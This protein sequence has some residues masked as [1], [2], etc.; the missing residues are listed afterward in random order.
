MVILWMVMALAAVVQAAPVGK[1]TNL[2]G[3]A[4]VTVS[5]QPAKA[6]SI[7]QA[8]NVGDIIRTKS[9]SKCEVTW[10]DGSIARMAADSRLQVTAF[11]L[12]KTSRK[13]ILSLFRGKVQN[14]VTS[15]AKLFGGKGDSQYEVHTPTSVCGVRGTTFF[16][17]YENGIS[18][19]L[20]A[21]GSGYMYSRGRPGERKTVTPGIWM[22]VANAH[23][24]PSARHATPGEM[25]K[26]FRDTNLSD[27]KKDSGKSEDGKGITVAGGGG[28]TGGTMLGGDPTDPTQSSPEVGGS[29][30][31]VVTTNVTG[32][33][34]EKTP[35]VPVTPP[36][37]MTTFSLPVVVEGVFDGTLK[38]TISNTTNT[39]TINLT[40]AGT[41]SNYV[42]STAGALSDGSTA[43][44]YLTGISG[45]WRGLFTGLSRKDTSVSILKGD[46]SGAYA[47][48]VGNIVRSTGYT[49]AP[50]SSYQSF[51]DLPLL[52][53]Q[54]LTIS[55]EAF[56][57]P[58][59]S[60]P[61][62]ESGIKTDGVTGYNTQSG[63]IL[64]IWGVNTLGGTY[65]NTTGETSK[66]IP[67]YHF[68]YGSPSLADHFAFGTVTVTD[69][70]LGHTTVSGVDSLSYLDR[71]YIGTLSLDYRGV[72]NDRQEYDSVGTG[73]Y[74]L[75]PLSWSGD[76]GGSTGF[77]YGPAS[78]YENYY[79]SEDARSMMELVAHDMGLVGGETPFW[80]QTSHLVAMGYIADNDLNPVSGETV[81]GP[82]LWNSSIAAQALTGSNVSEIFTP[83][84]EFTGVTAGI[85]KDG[86]MNGSAYAIYKTAAGQ[87][88]WLIGK[89]TISGSYDSDLG[90]WQAGGDL[91]PTQRIAQLPAGVAAEDLEVFH[92][93]AIGMTGGNFTDGQGNINN[94]E[95]I[96][97]TTF[98][99][100]GLYNEEGDLEKI[101]PLRW[102]IY[103]IQMVYS[104]SFTGKPSGDTTWTAKTGGYGPT[105][106]NAPFFYLADISGAWSADG[107]ITG[108]LSGRY[109]TP[110]YLGVLSGPFYGIYNVDNVDPSVGGWI[111]QSI[112]TYNVTQ[113]LAHSAT[114]GMAFYGYG[115]SETEGGLYSNMD[116]SMYHA[117]RA[118]GLLGGTTAPWSGSSD[119]MA[120]GLF[121][122]DTMPGTSLWNTAVE[123]KVPQELPVA[124]ETYGGIY[125]GY[126]AAL[127]R[128]TGY[129]GAIR[130]IYLTPPD[131]EGKSAAGFL[132]ADNTAGTIYRFGQQD[133]EEGYTYG[134]WESTG[135]NTLTAS[136]PLATGIDAALVAPGYGS[137]D[138]HVSGSFNG[139]GTLANDTYSGDL[140]FFVNGSTP[141]P[142]GVYDLK[143]GYDTGSG[144]FSGK[145]AGETAWSANLGG[146]MSIGDNAA[147]S[148]A[149]YNGG[150]EGYWIADVGGQWNTSNEI[151]G[152][153]VNGTFLTPTHMG[154][155]SGPL[156]GLY[157]VQG[158]DESGLYG[159]WVGQSVG[160][161]QGVP[162]S[163]VSDMYAEISHA[164][165]TYNGQFSYHS[166]ETQT[167]YYN[168]FYLSD[169][170]RGYSYNQPTANTYPNTNTEYYAD[171]T[172]YVQVYDANGNCTSSYGTWDTTKGLAFL[173]EPTPPEGETAISDGAYQYVG[174]SLSGAMSGLLGGTDS[175]WTGSDIPFTALGQFGNQGDSIWY[176][177]LSSYNHLN[178]TYTTYDGGA[179]V[180]IMGGTEINNNLDGKFLSLYVAPDGSAGYLGGPLSGALYPGI[181]MFKMDG[182][183]NRTQP[184]VSHNPGVLPEN[185]HDS[186]WEGSM[187]ANLA[188][189]FTGGGE[190]SNYSRYGAYGAGQALV[191]EIGYSSGIAMSIVN[192]ETNV[193]QNWGIYGML[194]YGDFTNPSASSWTAKVG[195]S[196]SFGAYNLYSDENGNRNATSDRGYWLADISDGALSA[197]GKL[198][199]TLANGKFITKTKLGILGGDLSGSLNST[200]NLW[201]AFSLGTWE[202]TPLAF[203]SRMSAG[204]SH[205]GREY[206]GQ[207]SY[208]SGETK[209]GYY[210]Y[211]YLSDNS[212]GYS[213]NQPTANTYPYTQTYYYQD[214]TTYSYGY[215]KNNTYFESHGTWDTTKSLAFL[216]EP[217]PPE[218][219]T[220]STDYACD[221]FTAISSGHMSGLLGGTDSLWTGSNIP[222]TV[223]G[224]FRN[225]RSSI[226]HAN[227]SSD[228]YLNDTY[229]TYDN[230][231]YV[232]IMGGTEINNNLEGKFLSLY[233][234]PDGSAGYLKG[235]LSGALH[236]EVGIFEMTGTLNRVQPS[237]SHNPGVLPENLRDSIWEGSMGATLAGQFTDGGKINGY[238]GYGAGE[239][240]ISE[241]GYGGYGGGTTL[242][243]VNWET[244]VAQNWGIYGMA[245]YGEFTNPSASVWKA[246]VGGNSSFGA[247][248]L[249]TDENGNRNA[250]D[251]WGYW[252]A[253]ISDGALDATG[254]LTGTLVNGKFITKTKLGIL[255]GDLSGSLNSTHNL[256]DAVSLGTWEG[257]PL[258]YSANL[259]G[260][261]GYYNTTKGEEG[262]VNDGGCITGLTGGLSSLFGGAADVVGLGVYSRN[263]NS[264]LF[265]MTLVNADGGPETNPFQIYSGGAWFPAGVDHPEWF[266]SKMM[267]FYARN[268]DGAKYTEIGLL[269]SGP[270]IDKNGDDTGYSVWGNLYSGTGMWEIPAGEDQGTLSQITKT[271]TATSLTINESDWSPVATVSGNLQGTLRMKSATLDGI[272]KWGIWMS[273]M[274]GTYT[275]TIP[276][277]WAGR[278]GWTETNAYGKPSYSLATLAGHYYAYDGALWGGI[279]GRFLNP[280]NTG[281]FT[282][283]MIGVSGSGNWQ[284]LGLGS[285]EVKET[286]AFSSILTGNQYQN[287]PGIVNNKEYQK[288]Y[289]NGSSEN[290]WFEP[291]RYE[292][293]YFVPDAGTYDVTRT[294][295]FE[296]A[297]RD[298]GGYVYK[299][300][301][302]YFPNGKWVL[303]QKGS[304]VTHPA[305]SGVTDPCLDLSDPTTSP[306]FGGT[307]VADP[308]VPFTSDN[309]YVR[310]FSSAWATNALVQNGA[311]TGIMG[312]LNNVS[313]W[314]STK[315]NKTNLIM[316]GSHDAYD[317][318]QI[319]GTTGYYYNENKPNGAFVSSL[320]GTIQD[321]SGNQN[322]LEGLII[323][324]YIDPDGYA[325]VLKGNVRGASYRGVNMWESTDEEGAATLYRYSTLASGLTPSDLLNENA[326]FR[327]NIGAGINSAVHGTFGGS[328]AIDSPMGIMGTTASIASQPDWGIFTMQIGLANTF[329]DKPEAATGWASTLF[330]SGMFG[331]YGEAY[332]DLGYWYADLTSGTWSGGKLT[333]TL[334]G[335]FLTHKKLG[336]L[337]GA[338]LGTYDG[339]TS[340][341]WQATS[342][343]TYLKTKDVLFSSEIWG[344]TDALAE[345]K[346]G[347]KNDYA[348]GSSY[349][350]WYGSSKAYGNSTYYNATAHTRTMTRFDIQGTGAGKPHKDVWVQFYGA[351]KIWDTADDTYTFVTK[352][353]YG[354]LTDYQNDMLNLEKDPANPGQVVAS[355]T[356]MNFRD[357]NFNGILAGTENLWTNLGTSAATP[358]S[359]MGDIDVFGNA[360]R[361]LFTGT[362]VSFDPLVNL[363]PFANSTSPI[364]GAYYANL[365][366]AFGTKTVADDTLDGMISGLYLTP[367]GKAGVLYGAFT[368]NNNPDIGFWKGSGELKGYQLLASTNTMTPETFAG[369]LVRNSSEFRWD[370]P[371]ASSDPYLGGSLYTQA[372]SKSETAFINPSYYAGW[373]G[374][375]FGIYSG[376]AGGTYDLTAMSSESYM[377]VVID[378]TS[379][380]YSSTHWDSTINPVA[381]NVRSGS[382]LHN[383]VFDP[384]TATGRLAVTA[385]Y[386]Q[387]V[388]IIQGGDIKGLFDPV[389]RTWQ[390]ATNGT[391]METTAFVNLVNTFATDAEKNA[392]M[393]AMKIPAISVGSVDLAGSRG[394]AGDFLSVN[395][396]GVNF[397]AYSTGQ[398][399][400]IF[401][402]NNVTGTYDVS[403]LNGALPAAVNLTA[404][405]MS[406]FSAAS[407][408][409]TPKVWNTAANKWGAEVTG[410]GTMTS[411]ATGIV[412]KGG[413]AGGL[414]GGVSG[415]FGG[416]AAGVVRTGV[417]TP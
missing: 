371:Y 130:T 131:A 291:L 92:D 308:T 296:S 61:Y 356:Q 202:G 310:S 290:G 110:L 80:S 23:S 185:L 96:M 316:M 36:T 1:V 42:L 372:Y 271:G 366:G 413:A 113:K 29:G 331:K 65:V 352:D 266:E 338:L 93:F 201:E 230:G 188:G 251:D 378:Q 158:S 304:G 252:M 136:A 35:V 398:A 322:P 240:L 238:S 268:W 67:L 287:E 5:G 83:D 369:M 90:I 380:S 142:F 288:P 412:F 305:G 119:F 21:E 184:S 137:I 212:R 155:L 199:G 182:V 40:G 301:Y 123:G 300:E 52:V 283:D 233:V 392:F 241:I 275:E 339:T 281:I 211:S 343:G 143:L 174:M 355:A 162:L 114:L 144:T 71:Q 245:L 173:K 154:T 272:D 127:W 16:S 205:A 63:G 46:L 167:G 325:G 101:I 409:F 363:N 328:G 219:E 170:S 206:T 187:S 181:G 277:R 399:P 289:W 345:G 49:V 54:N 335:E 148:V 26:F 190:I 376:V 69:D 276:E 293:N 267:G 59:V 286:L 370:L 196:S 341:T 45:S 150:N 336:T 389:A 294:I 122:M 367:D 157:T 243:I 89:D 81:V 141:L 168:Y 298:G 270:L 329:K 146:T 98:Y 135:T 260:S 106:M 403:S 278:T 107:T 228:N 411:P 385:N 22:F 134:L 361:K 330:G 373:T 258:A 284:A 360:P 416:T 6:L 334:N 236:P 94:Y 117:G 393:A 3:R 79:D 76:W 337:E 20:F 320:V 282:G 139:A 180:G 223:L 394:T 319:F 56:S 47:D 183:L 218:G 417:A 381:P 58:V 374:G 324:I 57:D 37:D 353:D 31:P 51:T 121:S 108:E 2:E 14:V 72:Y 171:G 311:F 262:L 208:H 153:V 177:S 387:G 7:G 28:S 292:T 234:A 18:G 323:G 365:G 318:S 415:Q 151:I 404:S 4:D 86:S 48:A 269:T 263:Q 239:P 377:S 100:K 55:G 254:K 140:T 13:T 402:T 109:M 314:E 397:Y 38:G 225:Q 396:T 303:I 50:E 166:G 30:G 302:H 129:T 118:F 222:F 344:N 386:T 297:R 125:T 274:G 99:G 68:S 84:A 214:G 53:L 133:G 178:D 209:T 327:G 195:G 203:V 280:D 88:G 237:V 102:G 408:T 250:T 279:Q 253:D 204:I 193:A 104:N 124:T 285:F 64:G 192:W 116:G 226:W 265:T 232:G 340:G 364:G 39:G 347:Y 25:N 9:S 191:S 390:A 362:V 19:S 349:N 257:T 82:L 400:R 115:Y 200:H 346:T 342:A 354:T 44:T 74:K 215:D 229:T 358:I 138:A 391:L 249:Y 315:D 405:N 244:N 33:I 103:D 66:N 145:P 105:Q 401:A 62:D 24:L 126:A 388:T 227:L 85:W 198:T 375:P 78:L 120:M 313:L 384:A 207:L 357:A 382:V 210:N 95:S 326:I 11:N 32:P 213:Y 295:A 255:S 186:I 12:Q 128:Q 160:T 156:Y 60:G 242:S 169:N 221:D 179:Y 406:N 164:A 216:T 350:Y 299:D 194:L 165:R 87:A 256:W 197:T 91:T 264:P 231:A 175:L 217:T 34:V 75:A 149:T 309:N 259:S 332:A 220:A 77:F 333:G 132:T 159:T 17:S 172:T 235:S 97:Q 312:G 368:G 43:N 163:H 317:G 176:T 224:Q 273:A 15:A 189:Q 395:M 73:V 70:L 152:N 112:G 306:N 8:V 379:A 359:L 383:G 27:K 307:V 348:D 147:V 10:V 41:E 248:N 261:W 321:D 414:S 161:Y 247:Y 111:G 407:A 410:S 246:K 351:D